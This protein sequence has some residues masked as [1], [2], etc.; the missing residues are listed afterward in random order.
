MATINNVDYD[1][2]AH[3]TREEFILEFE[4]VK[5][6][7]DSFNQQLILTKL[8]STIGNIKDVNELNDQVAQMIK[9]HF[10]YDRVMIYQFDHLWNGSIVAETKEEHLTSWL[11]L[12]YPST[13]IPVP[14]R[15]LFYLES[16]RT[17]KD[18]FAP[19]IDIISKDQI[20]I[21]LSRSELRAV[22]PVHIEYLTNMKVGA[23]LT[24][25]IVSGNSVWGLVAC[26]HYSPKSI[27]YKERLVFKFLTKF[28][29][30]QLKIIK[31][32]DL[33]KIIKASSQIRGELINQIVQNWNIQNGLSQYKYTINDLTDSQGSIIFINNKITAIGKCPTDGEVLSIIGR[34]K[35][36]TND[37]I[38]HTNHFMKDFP[39]A[40]SFKEVAA[41]VLCVFISKDKNDALLWFK[42]EI[43]KTIYWGCLLYTSPSPRD[44]QKS[45]MPSS[46]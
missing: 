1:I 8:V 31:A 2:T 41:G 25:P 26:H 39:E 13:D 17:V 30:S 9:L 38:Y 16:I 15:R 14:A 27:S 28:F 46:A 3:L 11:G 18:V 36:I 37:T 33:L 29:A 43:E 44:R 4:S 45:R 24:M 12:H 10:G 23:T 40:H 6:K 32:D 19:P 34:I 20:E 21:D 5:T 7:I 42:P 22:S 35:K